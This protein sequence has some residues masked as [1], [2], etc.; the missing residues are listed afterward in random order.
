MAQA[1]K[2]SP[3]WHGE[4]S[5]GGGA[6]AGGDL[7]RLLVAGQVGVWRRRLAASERWR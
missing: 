3:G 2:K 5:I 1:Y 6:A 7:K 4:A